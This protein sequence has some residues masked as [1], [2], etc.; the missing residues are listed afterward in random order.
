MR[1]V[2]LL[3]ALTATQVAVADTYLV[4]P[5]G[6]GDFPTIQ[7]AIDAAIDG[8]II[9][10]A[11]GIFYEDGNR[12]L[13]FL[14]KAITVRSVS[15]DPSACWI[16]CYDPDFE[17]E[18]RGVSFVNGETR[19]SVLEGVKISGGEV[20]EV[21][22]SGAGILCANGG[23]PTIRN[24]VITG[25][26]AD[27]RGAGAACESGAS[28]LFEDCEF[29]VNDAS[30]MYGG[31]CGGAVH[32]EDASPHFVG[33]HIAGNN[34]EGNFSG[35]GGAL[36]I[37]SSTV[38]IEDCWIIDNTSGERGGGISIG[39][40]DVTITGTVFYGNIS[41]AGYGGWGAAVFC[42][43]Y[44]TLELSECTISRNS[45]TYSG[46]LHCE[47]HANA[48]VERTIVWDNWGEFAFA[49]ITVLED[50]V[51]SLTCCDVGDETVGGDGT[52]DFV[53]DNIFSDPFFCDSAG[54][55]FELA[56]GSPCAPENSP[57]GQLIGA[58]GVGCEVGT[59]LPTVDTTWG[60]L[61]AT[62]K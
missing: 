3:L 32:S 42:T 16:N 5:D 61:K 10:L 24:C 51:L 59:V 40:S 14:G 35:S 55:N 13:D 4:E 46:G 44:S 2:L 53:S 18:H 17:A 58:L 36:C 20:H 41:G 62:F 8:D 50:A 39:S 15:G 28:P 54:Y 12:D 31:G 26:R 29:T 21:L 47:G 57:C 11:D 48:T 60:R 22:F 56:E 43:G 6:T 23:S 25:C 52:I 27:T 7:A 34:T 19:S 9:E 37:S 45:G 38:T 33:C 30:T 1:N 49:D